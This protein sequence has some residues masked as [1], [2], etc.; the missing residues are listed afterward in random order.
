MQ[1]NP[2]PREKWK[3]YKRHWDKVATTYTIF[4][5]LLFLVISIQVRQHTGQ[6]FPARDSAVMF[7]ST[8]NVFGQTKRGLSHNNYFMAIFLD[9]P[10][11]TL[12]LSAYAQ[13]NKV[14]KH[15]YTHN[16]CVCVCVFLMGCIFFLTGRQW[17]FM[18]GWQGYELSGRCSCSRGGAVMQPSL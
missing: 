15:T 2:V 16:T 14:K 4:F 18:Q 3:M 12:D 11:S 17:Y 6:L 7:A 8:E 9:F 1:I 13:N 5:F 10:K